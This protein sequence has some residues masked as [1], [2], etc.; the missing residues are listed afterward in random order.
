[1]YYGVKTFEDLNNLIKDA[2]R[3]GLYTDSEQFMNIW[4]NSDTQSQIIPNSK[5]N[6]DSALR[7]VHVHPGSDYWRKWHHRLIEYTKLHNDPATRNTTH[8]IKYDRDGLVYRFYGYNALDERVDTAVTVRR[9]REVLRSLIPAIDIDVLFRY[10]QLK[11]E[12][13]K[14]YW[15]VDLSGMETLRGITCSKCDALVNNEIE[16]LSHLCNKR[17]EHV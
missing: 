8:E 6:L 2:H 7:W 15:E 16:L 9:Q 3:S 10:L 4:F 14:N 12:E 5:P 11:T 1:M 17:Y 13:G